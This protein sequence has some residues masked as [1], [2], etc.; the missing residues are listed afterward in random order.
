MLAF[1]L[2]DYSKSAMAQN[3]KLARE[4]NRDGRKK[5]GERGGRI[6]QGLRYI[7]AVSRI[8]RILPP[9]PRASRRFGAA[10]MS[11]SEETQSGHLLIWQEGREEEI[12][13]REKENEMLRIFHPQFRSIH[14]YMKMERDQMIGRH[15]SYDALWH[16]SPLIVNI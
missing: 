1:D 12:Q 13:G 15:S 9:S 2:P 3:E 7:H 14:P 5:E 11:E 10:V 4:R 8:S 6:L 16:R